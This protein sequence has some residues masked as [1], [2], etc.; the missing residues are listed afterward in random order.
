MYRIWNLLFGW[1]YVHWRNTADT[2]IARIHRTPDS[3]VWYYRYK[4][5]SC[6]D[7][8]TP[9]NWDSVVF[10]TCNRSKYFGNTDADKVLPTNAK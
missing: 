10:L 6:I 2:G 4:S 7:V 1:D 9:A 8:I 3:V 5:T